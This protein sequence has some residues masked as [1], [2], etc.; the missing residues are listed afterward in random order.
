MNIR[1]LV[2]SDLATNVLE[3]KD[4]PQQVDITA[5]ADLVTSKVETRAVEDVVEEDSEEVRVFMV[6]VMLVIFVF[7]H[8]PLVYLI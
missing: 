5:A 1:Q 4:D 6:S 2:L 7:A 3:A 8:A